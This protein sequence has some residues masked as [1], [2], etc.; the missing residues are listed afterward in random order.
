MELWPKKTYKTG[1]HQP[2]WASFYIKC[3][4]QSAHLGEWKTMKNCW[5]ILP[6]VV[7]F[8]WASHT[9]HKASRSWTNVI[10]CASHFGEQKQQ[11]E[12]TQLR[13]LIEVESYIQ[14]FMGTKQ[15]VI[16]Y[17]LYWSF[18]HCTS[19]NPVDIQYLVV[20][21]F[22]FESMIPSSKC[23]NLNPHVAGSCKTWQHVFL[24]NCAM[25]LY[26]ESK[27]SPNQQKRIQVI[28]MYISI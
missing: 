13:K 6:L 7:S 27:Q 9:F 15:A 21:H 19:G 5:E 18:V 25:H 24:R 8:G 4:V 26:L 10:R 20:V 12:M 23:Q 14:S 3:S 28:H 11:G 2:H 1:M 22:N 16:R 17:H